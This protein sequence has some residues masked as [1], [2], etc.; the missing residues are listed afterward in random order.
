MISK[1][2][3]QILQIL[4]LCPE[5]LEIMKFR[6]CA[7]KKLYPYSEILEIKGKS[8]KFFKITP[9]CIFFQNKIKDSLSCLHLS[10]E[11]YEELGYFLGANDKFKTSF[12]EHSGIFPYKLVRTLLCDT[13]KI[14]DALYVEELGRARGLSDLMAEK[15]SVET[16]I[17]ANPQSWFGIENILRKKN[18]CTCLYISYFQNR[19]HLWILKTSGVLH[20]RR[21]SP[22]ENLVQAGLPKDLSLSQFLDDNFR[23]L[24]ILPT[25]DC[26]DRSLNTIELQP[27]SPAQKSSA[28]LRL[29]EEDE[30]KDEEVIS[31]LSLCYKR[32]ITPVYDLLEEPEINI[33]PDRS[34][35]KVP[36]A[37]LSEKE[38]AEYLSETHRIR[39][40]PSLTTLKMIQ[41]SLEDYHSSTGAL[42][43]G[44]PK[45]GRCLH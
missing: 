15:Y 13:G 1:G 10:I 29:V 31:S 41:N 35:Y 3:Q 33:G 17:S 11:K 9:F 36:F 22:E 40:I 14:R 4:E 5:L 6:K 26:E 34:L 45:V 24:G 20:Y 32:F 38:G 23:S 8:S 43:M 30:D 21:V 19:L 2:R 39:V 42:I 25:K 18:N 16:H 28:R 44:N 12:L 37:A 27:L 7:W